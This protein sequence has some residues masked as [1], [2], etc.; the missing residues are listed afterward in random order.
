M[1]QLSGRELLLNVSNVFV[2]VTVLYSVHSGAEVF[3]RERGGRAG[4]SC[5]YLGG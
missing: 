4:T 5:V 3:S 1:V 2:A